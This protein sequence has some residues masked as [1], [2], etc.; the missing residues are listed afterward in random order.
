MWPCPLVLKIPKEGVTL[1]QNVKNKMSTSRPG[2]NKHTVSKNKCANSRWVLVVTVSQCPLKCSK[3]SFHTPLIGNEHVQPDSFTHPLHT[4]LD[5]VRKSLNQLLETFKWQFAQDETSMGTNHLIKMQIDMGDSELVLQRPYP[6]AM[7]HYDWV[8]SEINKPLDAQVNHSSHSSWSTTIIVV[9]KGDSGK[10]L[11]INYRA[12]NKVTWKFVWPMPRVKEIFSKLMVLSISQH[13]ISTL[14]TITYPL[15]KPLFPK[16][17]LHLLLE[18][19]NIW[20]FLLDWHK[21]WHIS[22]KWWIKY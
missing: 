12:W 5:D 20:K 22:K 11:M 8:S 15:M 10:F 18:N 21:H 2:C 16:Q 7:K 9:P 6:I 14:G 4:L 19:M 13:S 3:C 17:P 1:C